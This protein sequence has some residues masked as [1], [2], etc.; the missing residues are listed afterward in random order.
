MSRPISSY[1]C[2]PERLLKSDLV[3][4]LLNKNATLIRFN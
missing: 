1:A 2:F 4:S 3:Y